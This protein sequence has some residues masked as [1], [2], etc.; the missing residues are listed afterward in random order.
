[1]III[2]VSVVVIV[3]REVVVVNIAVGIGYCLWYYT[4][5]CNMV[6]SVDL[7]SMVLLYYYYF[8]VI[9]IVSTTAHL[10]AVTMIDVVNM[11]VDKY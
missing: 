8:A 6:M 3:I 5:V 11:V 7:I 9:V 1:M 4:V 2:I 10:H